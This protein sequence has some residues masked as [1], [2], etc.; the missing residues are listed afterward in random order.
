MIRA[1]MMQ[2]G[3]T[4]IAPVTES[5]R[6]AIRTQLYTPGELLRSGELEPD[7]KAAQEASSQLNLFGPPLTP[8]EAP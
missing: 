6:A 5:S 4:L 7:V 1:V 3:A 8:S 2:R